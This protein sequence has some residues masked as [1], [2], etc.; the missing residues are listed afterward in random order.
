MKTLRYL[1]FLFLFS[2][3][4]SLSHFTQDKPLSQRLDDAR[5]IASAYASDIK[6]SLE[7]V[8]PLM[9]KIDAQKQLNVIKTA[10]DDI[11]KSESLLKL[12]DVKGAEARYKLIDTALKNVRASLAKKGAK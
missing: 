3:C 5:L 4:A 7:A 6:E 1:P 8:P 2:A 11:D 10:R 9:T 12:G